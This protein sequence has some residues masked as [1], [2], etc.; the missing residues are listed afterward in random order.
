MKIEAEC[1]DYESYEVDIKHV[2]NEF[3]VINSSMLIFFLE[4]IQEI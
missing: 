4:I 3:T 1:S 2:I